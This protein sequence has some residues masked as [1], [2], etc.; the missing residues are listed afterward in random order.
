M[1]SVSVMSGSVARLGSVS[2][3]L[4]KGKNVPWK[5]KALVTASGRAPSGGL[6]GHGPLHSL[7]GS[8]T[9]LSHK[10]L[11]AGD[12]GRGRICL[13]YLLTKHTAKAHTILPSL[14]VLIVFCV[15]LC[16]STK[17]NS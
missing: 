8:E 16:Q 6:L 10:R 11:C 15:L 2:F 5:Q 12:W 9:E 17:L 7:L 3:S 14:C 13:P 4:C 1:R